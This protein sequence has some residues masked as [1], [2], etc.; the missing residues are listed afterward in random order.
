MAEEVVAA[1][2]AQSRQSGE[3]EWP[4]LPPTWRVEAPNGFLEAKSAAGALQQVDATVATGALAAFQPIA[5]GFQ[6][7][8]RRM[9][10]GLRPGELA[11]VGGGQGIG[12]TAMALQMARNIVTS[13]PATCLYVCYE[14]D[15]ATLLERLISQESI[16]PSQD[17]YQQGLRTRDIESLIIDG[18]KRRRAGL[19]ESISADPRGAL[20]MRRV[21][22]YSDRLFLVKASGV[23]TTTEVLRRFVEDYRAQ[24]D[25]RLVMFVDYLQRMPVIPDSAD[26]AGRVTR[27]VE[28]LKEIALAFDITVVAIAAA[29]KEGLQAKRLRLYHLRG[30]SAVTY[31]AD[32]ILI[33]NEKYKIVTKTSIE[34]NL[35]RAQAYHDWVVVS[36][37]KNRSGRAAVDV[38]FRQRFEYSCF[39]PRGRD[40]E[41]HL[42]DERIFTE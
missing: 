20:A 21:A 12:K 24:S 27:I 19:I 23:Y 1:T 8:D 40:V 34:F 37:E 6:A 26:E 10:G 22:A 11:L 31:E 30:S 7:L 33:L 39:D 28:A 14:H 5:T 13:G 35:H 4:A 3:I 32:I 18:Y 9:Q 38:E 41:E 25:G 42:V 29:D 16:T 17:G 2:A 36:V 15:E